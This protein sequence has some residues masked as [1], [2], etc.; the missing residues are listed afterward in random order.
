MKNALDELDFGVV[1]EQWALE[2]SEQIWHYL[3]Y[4]L[5]DFERDGALL[6]GESEKFT[7]KS[8]EDALNAVDWVVGAVLML[9]V[10]VEIFW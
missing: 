10:H 5:L 7:W 9:R 6:I 2:K 3:Q 1:F 8:W 4:V